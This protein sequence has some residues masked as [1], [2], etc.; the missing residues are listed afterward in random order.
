MVAGHA[1]AELAD[2]TSHE[3]EKYFLYDIV[4]FGWTGW[5]DVEEAIYRFAKGGA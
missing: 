5:I 4:H 1:S 3:Y 2:F